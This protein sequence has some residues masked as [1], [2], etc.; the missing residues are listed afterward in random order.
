VVRDISERKQIKEALR[1]SEEMHR[2][3]IEN[4]NEAIAV[5]QDGKIVF[6]N[7]KLSL[8]TG[9]SAEELLLRPFID[10]LH[11][12]DRELVS[13]RHIRRLQGE[14]IPRHSMSLT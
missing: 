7:P 13:S 11:P 4:A 9:Y 6:L 10:I 14:D 3:F 2:N 12:D 1:I 8:M 5:T